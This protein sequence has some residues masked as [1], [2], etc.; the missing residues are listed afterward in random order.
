MSRQG[1]PRG[2]VA[3]ANVRLPARGHLLSVATCRSAD[4]LFASLCAPPD[5]AEAV[6]G[7][8]KIHLEGQGIA[9]IDNLEFLGPGVTHLYL[10]GNL[11]ER[12]ENLEVVPTV[13]VLALMDNVITKLAGVRM[14]TQLEVLDVSRN[15]IESVDGV[16]LPP[17]IR[18]L[19]LEGNPCTLRDGYR[20]TILRALPRLENLDGRDVRAE[21]RKMHA[22]SDSDND[23]EYTEDEYT[24]DSADEGERAPADEAKADAADSPAA[25]RTASGALDMDDVAKRFE[26]LQAQV[27][28]DV[29]RVRQDIEARQ[30]Q[31]QAETAARLEAKGK[32]KAE[33]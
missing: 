1:D 21:R 10:Q 29:S 8:T 19:N 28:S 31:R 9:E 14:L 12:V 25:P 15:D 30:A 27:S 18:F 32:A 3:R 2:H 4:E 22:Q 11:I 26:A 33:E 6:V 23:D 20:E 13:K 17:S 16:D 7:L 24:D 5:S